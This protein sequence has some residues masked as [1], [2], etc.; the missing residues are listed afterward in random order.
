MPAN[1]NSILSSLIIAM[2][3]MPLSLCAQ[4]SR[5]TWSVIDAGFSAGA[6]GNT[7]IHAAAGQTFVGSFSESNVLIASGFLAAPALRGPVTGASRVDEYPTDFKLYR[8]F[9]NPFNPS[10]TFLFVLPE[11]TLVSLRIYD[12]M[13]REVATVVHDELSPGEHSVVWNADQVASGVYY[14]SMFAGQYRGNGKIVLV[15]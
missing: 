4:Q 15:K 10:T 2:L 5:V 9:P 8:N 11:A 14:F 7:A 13:G 1:S 3:M 6:G 12:L